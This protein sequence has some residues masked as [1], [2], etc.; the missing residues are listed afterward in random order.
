M[1]TVHLRPN[2]FRRSIQLIRVLGEVLQTIQRTRRDFC[3]FTL[4][5]KQ[6]EGDRE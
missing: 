6:A 2:N 1:C 4:R 5:E 3:T